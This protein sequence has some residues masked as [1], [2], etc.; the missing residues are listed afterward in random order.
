MRWYDFAQIVLCLLL[1]FYKESII[2]KFSEC[3]SNIARDPQTLKV[4][5]VQRGLD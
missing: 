2:N 1:K 5:F 3:S 4:H